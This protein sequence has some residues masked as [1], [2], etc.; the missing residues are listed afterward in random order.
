M[1]IERP[2]DEDQLGL[3]SLFNVI[4]KGKILILLFTF[5]F[6]ASAAAISLLL[7][8]KYTSSSLLMLVDNEEENSIASSFG[9]LGGIASMAGVD[10]GAGKVEKVDELLARLN[11]RDFL[12]HLLTFE[13]VKENLTAA[14]DYDS[15]NKKTLFNKKIYDDSSGKWIGKSNKFKQAIPSTLESQEYFNNHVSITFNKLNSLIEISVEHYSPDFSYTF[16]NLIINEANNI[17]KEIDVSH[18]EKSI[19]YLEELLSVTSNQDLRSSINQ[20]MFSEIRKLMLANIDDF[21]L[22]KPIDKAF[23][24]E[25]RSSPKRTQFSIIGGLLGMMLSIFILLLRFFIRNRY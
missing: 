22:L 10:V 9:A 19:A 20:L 25:R 5:V 15:I 2:K 4:W 21:Y 1:N 13:M 14:N 12:E 23:K 6:L 16:L 18:Y 24:P 7:P 8:N 3:T 17:S 11:S